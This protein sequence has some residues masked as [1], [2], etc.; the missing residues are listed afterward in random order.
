MWLVKGF[1]VGLLFVAVFSVMYVREFV[2]PTREGVATGLSVI[3]TAFQ[4]PIYWVVLVA[5][6]TTSCL[7]REPC[8]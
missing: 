2:G 1:V 4:M 7:W 3:R 6:V 8:T 5:I